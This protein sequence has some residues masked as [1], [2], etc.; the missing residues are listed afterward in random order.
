M[1][2]L[3]FD[4]LG[5]YYDAFGTSGDEKEETGVYYQ[6]CFSVNLGVC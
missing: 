6:Y 3:G 1:G 4:D 5:D 2:L